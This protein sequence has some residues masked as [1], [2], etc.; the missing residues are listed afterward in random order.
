MIR[1]MNTQLQELK[2]M[3]L[4]G[5]PSSAYTENNLSSSKHTALNF[6]IFCASWD[7]LANQSLLLK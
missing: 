5:C 7:C 6:T 4:H 1:Y 2:L 3:I